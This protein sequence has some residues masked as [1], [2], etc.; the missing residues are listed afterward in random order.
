MKQST[1]FEHFMAKDL[2]RASGLPH[3]AADDHEVV[4]D[5]LKV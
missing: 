5:L 3:L 2:F 4:K 1:Q